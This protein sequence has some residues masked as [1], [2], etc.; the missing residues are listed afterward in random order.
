MFRKLFLALSLA[1]TWLGIARADSIA[2]ATVIPADAAGTKIADILTTRVPTVGRYRVTFADPAFS[3]TLPAS[4]QGQY[5][6]A[7]LSYDATRRNFA[8]SFGYTGENGQPLYVNVAGS[9]VPMI[10]VPAPARD[11]A[12]GEVVAA[13]DIVMIEVPA[14]RASAT[15]ITTADTVAGQAARRG[16]RARQPLFTYDLKKFALIKKGD[17]IN[18]TFAMPGIELSVSGQALMEGGQGDVISVLNVRSRRTV[19][20]RITGAGNVIVQA[21]TATLAAAQQ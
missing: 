2:V 13:S 14:E 8:A 15:L 10:D 18:I 17:L 12:T 3:L 16:L 19:E 4:A 20:G 7:A 5:T 9:A 21:A 1:L 6:I 11:I